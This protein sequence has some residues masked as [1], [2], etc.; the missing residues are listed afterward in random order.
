MTYT[1]KVRLTRT[2]VEDCEVEI[3]SKNQLTLDQINDQAIDAS[4]DSDWAEVSGE[5][6]ID[7]LVICGEQ[8]I[9]EASHW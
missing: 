3:T 2:I 4:E 6:G 5:G 9:K 1:Y 8:Y 7:T